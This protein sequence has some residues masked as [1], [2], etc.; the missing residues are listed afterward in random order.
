MPDL[1]QLMRIASSCQR[2]VVAS[3]VAVK[4]HHPETMGEPLYKAVAVLD[5]VD[6]DEVENSAAD[7]NAVL[8]DS[9]R[10]AH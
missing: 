6:D 7:F 1:L 5:K 3:S 2:G 9:D 8:K 10:S 4:S